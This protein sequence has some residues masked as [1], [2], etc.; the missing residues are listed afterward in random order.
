[1]NLLKRETL[2]RRTLLRGLGT[3]MSVPWLEA[4]GPVTAW[5]AEAKAGTVAP[6]RMAFL[7]V[8]NG[9]NMADWTPAEDGVL[10]SLP[11]TLEPLAAL[12]EEI[13]VL[14][15]LTADGARPHGDGGGDH[16]RALSSF[17]TGAHPHKTDGLQIRNGISVDQVAAA[18]VGNRTRLGSLE[19]GGEAGAMAGNCDSGYSCVYSSTMAWRSATQPLPKE[20]NP[21][22]VFERLFGSGQSAEKGRREAM[23]RSILDYVREDAQDLTRRLGAGDAR[24]LDEYFTAVREIELR[25]EQAAR[26]PPVTVPEYAVPAGIPASYEEHL[27][28]LCDLMV[29]AFQT[30]VTRVATFVLANEGSNRPYP[31]AGASEGHHDLSHHGGDAAKQAK[32]RQINLFHMKQFAYL[33]GK[34]ASVREGDGTLLDH[35]MIAYGSAIADGNAHNHEDLPVLLAGRGCGTILPGRHLRYGKETPIANLWVSMLRRMDVTAEKLG[36]STGTLP[37]LEK[38]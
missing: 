1:M 35:S 15:G 4:M 2:S 3:V 25:I 16:A 31:F 22:L 12:R 24:K 34:L 23:R 33:L 11:P 36:D 18:Q 13:L 6:C 19:I 32:L 10:R 27:R 9:V 29:L 37:G 30:D 17:L 38:A 26:L 20:V 21:K 8:P 5:S 14:S 28:I 7:Y